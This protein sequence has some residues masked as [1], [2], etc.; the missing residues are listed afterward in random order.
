MTEDLRP[1][2]AGTGVETEAPPGTKLQQNVE[3]KDIGPCKKHIKVTVERAS[4]D[5]RLDGKF[6][7]LVPDSHVAGFRP[8]KAPRKLV[9][10]RFRKEVAD[11]VK[12]EVLLASLEQLAEEHDIAPLSAP[13][14]DPFKIELPDEGP[15]VYE[16]EVEV[17][18]QFDL[19]NYKG[20]KLK[21][22]I[23]KFSDADVA[24]EKRQIL[25]P[26]CQVVPKDGAAV[27]GDVITAQVTAKDESRTLKT[28]PEVQLRLETRLAF[29]DG[30]VENFAE[31]FQGSKPGDSKTVDVQLSTAVE[32][33]ALR[34]KKVQAD[35]QVKDVKTLRT[36]ESSEAFFREFGVKSEDQFDEVLRV[37]LQ[38]R[39][40][41]VE[42]QTIRRQVT[43]QLAAN[44]N[45]QLPQDL[46]ARQA[47]KTLNRQVMEMQNN[48]IP[49]E[50][51]R[52]R[53]RLLQQNAM[54]S[55]ELALKEHFVLQKIAEVEKIDVK[56]DD[57][58]DEIERIADQNNESPRRVRA[59]LEKDDLI[60]SLAAD[61]IERQALELILQ[62]AEY[63]D[64][65][66][67]PRKEPPVF[68]VEEQL[69]PGQ[70][71]DPA[72]VAAPETP[73]E[74]PSEA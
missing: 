15:L 44:A 7:K 71:I 68:T 47:Q 29:M 13:N 6:S 46:L 73:A 33:E 24:S 36:P 49:V 30:V 35:I 62:S 50:E 26:Y 27:P 22:P 39:M 70:L 42:R 2:D 74:T 58:N 11:E 28:L 63:E 67:D 45:W 17:R 32:E 3:I 10:R 69:T 18:P 31:Q 53:A 21:R 14:L 57:I 65:A 64:V 12:A 48:G 54:Q 1:D 66:Y 40:D 16:F 8:G 23:Y 19:P 20:L 60:E 41:Y 38:R 25:A 56:E 5:E 61:M 51:I 59:R 52:G 37:V 55:T 43:E 4:I 34:G 72:K 9:Q